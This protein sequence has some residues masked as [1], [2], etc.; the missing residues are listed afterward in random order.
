MFLTC[1]VTMSNLDLS[2]PHMCIVE[3]MA[4]VMA[5][6]MGKVKFTLYVGYCECIL[7]AA[8]RG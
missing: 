3:V 2:A 8:L 4:E 7:N 1:G 6:V 5:E